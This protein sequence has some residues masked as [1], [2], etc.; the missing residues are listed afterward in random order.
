MLTS[1]R[2]IE[3]VHQEAVNLNPFKR[4]SKSGGG[5][6][7]KTYRICTNTVAST[8]TIEGVLWEALALVCLEVAEDHQFSKGARLRVY[9]L[10]GIWPRQ[11][12]FVREYILHM[13]MRFQSHLLFVLGFRTTSVPGGTLRAPKTNPHTAIMPAEPAA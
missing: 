5:G 3:E 1:I 12:T 2:R 7:L 9:E 13:R 11:Q 4:K 10:S 6:Q 8:K